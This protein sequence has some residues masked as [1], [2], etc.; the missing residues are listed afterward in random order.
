LKNGVLRFPILFSFAAPRRRTEQCV[1]SERTVL[2]WSAP[3]LRA[4]L[5]GDY[6]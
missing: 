6:R 4:T 3:L 1:T 2:V 5:I